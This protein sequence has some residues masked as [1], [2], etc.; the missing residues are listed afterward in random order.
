M[1]YAIGGGVH[2]SHRTGLRSSEQFP[3]SRRLDAQSPPDTMPTPESHS[4]GVTESE[5]KKMCYTIGGGVHTS[6][7][8]N[9]RSSEQF[10]PSRRLDAQS[11]PDTMP[12]PESH[13]NGV[14]ELARN[15]MCYIIGGGVH[16][17]HRTGLRSSE[18]FPPSRRLDAQSP[19][20]TMPTP[21]SHSN[22]VTERKNVLRNWGRV[23]HFSPYSQELRTI[24][25]VK[26]S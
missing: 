22:G 23:S 20:D 12:T 26:A 3:P 13:S 1:C 18:Q 14:T 16:T 4:N 25:T 5:R 11:P 6:Q 24:P 19:P 17:S 7:R 9:L 8:T 10:P 15:K 21:E 2:T